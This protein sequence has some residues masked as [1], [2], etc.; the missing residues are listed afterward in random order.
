[1]GRRVRLVLVLRPVFVQ[2]FWIFCYGQSCTNKLSLESRVSPSFGCRL[3]NAAHCRGD[4]AC[5]LGIAEML[6]LVDNIVDDQSGDYVDGL[7][8]VRG[9]VDGLQ[10]LL[11]PY[12]LSPC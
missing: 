9:S 8:G 2:R 1:V 3:H 11:P 12:R 4:G 10:R 5:M 7:L 6:D